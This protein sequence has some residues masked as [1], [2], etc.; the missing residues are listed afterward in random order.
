MTRGEVVEHDIV[1]WDL[2]EKFGKLVNVNARQNI[3]SVFVCYCVKELFRNNDFD[4]FC[5]R[6]VIPAK[7]ITP[8]GAFCVFLFVNMMKNRSKNILPLR[9]VLFYRL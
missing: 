2:D 6:L 5:Q 8:I 3:I 7:K 4:V 1:F 9:D